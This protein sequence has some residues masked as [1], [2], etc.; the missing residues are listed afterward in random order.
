MKSIPA[1]RRRTAGL[2]LALALVST[3]TAC[4]DDSADAA[5]GAQKVKFGYIADYSTWTYLR[6]LRQGEAD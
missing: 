6:E 3:A 1:V 4:G 2:L 5:G